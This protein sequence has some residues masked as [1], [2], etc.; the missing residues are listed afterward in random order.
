MSQE[1]SP[2]SIWTFLKFAPSDK[3]H[4]TQ[5]LGVGGLYAATE[6]VRAA[7]APA[8]GVQREILDL[9][10]FIVPLECSSPDA[11]SEVLVRETGMHSRNWTFSPLTHG[12]I[13]TG[14]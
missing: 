7:L 14:Q 5:L 1:S 11:F 12:L 8:P 6:Q 3:Q 2:L 10:K 9:G 4:L 13:F